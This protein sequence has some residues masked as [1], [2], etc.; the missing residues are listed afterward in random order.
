MLPGNGAP[1]RQS[2][3][4][5]KKGW[6]FGLNKNIFLRQNL[7]KNLKNHGFFKILSD[8]LINETRTKGCV[9]KPKKIVRKKVLR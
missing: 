6:C 8:K 7:D 3:K 2:G 9:K 4:A 5:T 1:R